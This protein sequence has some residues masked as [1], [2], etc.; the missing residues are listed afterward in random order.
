[1]SIQSA[2]KWKY[3]GDSLLKKFD[4]DLERVRA[5]TEQRAQ[6]HRITMHHPKFYPVTRTS[7]EKRLL[8][9][10]EWRWYA[11]GGI[12]VILIIILIIVARSVWCYTS[13]RDC[14][15]LPFVQ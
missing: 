1:M 10:V 15:L 14:K 6:T 12:A 11:W 7:Y 3:S 2:L 8:S 4:Q 5:N 9:N 13:V